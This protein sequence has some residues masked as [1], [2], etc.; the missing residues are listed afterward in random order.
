MEAALSDETERDS[1]CEMGMTETL[2][3][4]QS[5]SATRKSAPQLSDTR[6]ALNESEMPEQKAARATTDDENPS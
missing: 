3:S 2:M 6:P 4:K 1:N 5:V